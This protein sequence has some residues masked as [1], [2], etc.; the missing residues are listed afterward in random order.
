MALLPRGRSSSASLRACRTPGSI[1]AAC[2]ACSIGSQGP[3]RTV[4]TYLI[5]PPS[6][7]PSWPPSRSRTA[8]R[9]HEVAQTLVIGRAGVK[10]HG[11]LA[12]GQVEQRLAARLQ[13]TRLHRGGLQ[14]LFD[15]EPG[16]E[17]HG[18]NISDPPAVMVALMAAV[19]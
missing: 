8:P 15:R 11:A 4:R 13:D 12:P 5:R 9:A 10:D 3:K 7:S 6:W 2:R 19:M 1:G 16:A 17:T 14:G 18:P